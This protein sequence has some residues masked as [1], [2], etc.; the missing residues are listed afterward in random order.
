MTSKSDLVSRLHREAAKAFDAEA[1]SLVADLQAQTPPAPERQGST[2]KH[3]I[4]LNGDQVDRLSERVFEH[5]FDG[6]RRAC[7]FETR[8]RGSLCLDGQAHERLITLS[9]RLAAQPAYRDVASS[10]FAYNTAIEWLVARVER[11]EAIPGLC[12][13]L[14]NATTAATRKLEVWLPI[15]IVSI[16]HPIRIGRTTFRRVTKSMVDDWLARVGADASNADAGVDFLRSQIQG[17]TAACVEVEGEP[18]RAAE[19]AAFETESAVAMLRL[20]CPALMS[21]R[22]WAPLAPAE[23]SRTVGSFELH[24]EGQRIV[25]Q[26]AGMPPGMLAQWSIRKE[27][28]PFHF[29]TLWSFGNDLI[30]ADR[31]PFQE[32]LLDA[33]VHFSKS[34][35]RPEAA[36]RLMYVTTALESLLVARGGENIVQNLRER[37]AVVRAPADR[38]RALELVA[39][40]YQM[41]SDFVHRA[42]PVKDLKLLHEFLVDA[43]AL[44]LFL[45]NNHSKWRTKEELLK[46]LDA[47]KFTGPEF[48]TRIT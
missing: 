45:L 18:I 43:W 20:A 24:V 4:E 27:D 7:Y 14:D 15:P 1:N 48:S 47:H 13:F 42:L 31:S 8:A 9:R 12:A 34:V 19:M 37:M 36:D 39:L 46:A 32:L 40:V 25:G 44:M 28:V 10:E 3:V 21:A 29:R 30:L 33:I 11:P 23:I 35:L 38:L 6:D 17:C 26:R 41:R 5:D 16:P 2:D 22:R